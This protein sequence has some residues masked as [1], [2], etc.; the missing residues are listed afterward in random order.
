MWNKALRIFTMVT[1]L[2][3]LAE[4]ASAASGIEMLVNKLEEKGILNHSEAVIILKEVEN[5]I[6]LR[7]E[8]EREAVAAK[9][10][11][12]IKVNGDV[13]YRNHIDWSESD[14]RDTRHRQ[15]VR[16]RLGIKG[17]VNDDVEAGVRVVS[18]GVGPVS[19]NQTLGDFFGTKTFML[20]WAYIKYSPSFLNDH[21]D[22]YAGMFK[23]PF[24]S[25]ELLWDTDVSFGGT[26]LKGS[27]N[28]KEIAYIKDIG[29]PATEIFGT[30]GQFPLDEIGATWDDPWLWAAQGGFKSQLC[31]GVHLKSGMTIYDFDE[32]QRYIE[33]NSQGGNT[34]A[35]AGG[36]GKGFTVLDVPIELGIKDPARFLNIDSGDKPLIPYLAAYGD[37]A[38][39]LA[40]GEGDNA[41]MVGGKFGYKKVKK[42]GQ[43]QL[44]YDY[45]DLESNSMVD[46]FP[47]SDFGGTGTGQR[48]HNVRAVYGIADNTTLAVE[49]YYITRHALNSGFAN[50]DNEDASLLQLDANVKF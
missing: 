14:T 46:V 29:L 30:I 19:T 27:I 26:A 9:W 18:G 4:Q 42:P 39:N 7:V 28:T 34:A 35:F 24:Y 8:Q 20:D 11:E 40:T 36:F 32:I 17:E 1:L 41:W 31:D 5:E 22:L 2:L 15:R 23:N 25:T 21:V 3:S 6:A 48:G 33:N 49:W 38:N 37:Y 16:A 13:R 47:D 10:P 50:N 44:A 12:R 43:W 45:R